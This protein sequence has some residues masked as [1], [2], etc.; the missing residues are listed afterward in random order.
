[1]TASTIPTTMSV[2]HFVG[3]GHIGVI[4]KPVGAPGSGQLLLQVKANALCGSERGQFANGSTVTPGH[5]AAGIVVAAGPGTHTPIG[6]PGV[7][8]LI[9][10]CGDCRSC[11]LGFTNQCLNKR[12]DMGFNKDGGYG[13]FETVSEHI[14]FPVDDDIPLADA[15]MLLD[16]MGTSAHAIKRGLQIRAD[17]ESVLITG[18]G[19]VGLGMLAMT[20]LLLGMATPVLI[21]DI[22]PYRLAL[23]ERLGGVPID[24]RNQNL[25]DGARAAGFET[26]DMAIDT[27]GK[28]VAR[29]AALDLLGKRGALVCVGHGEEVHLTVSS[30]LIAPERAVLGSEYFCFNELPASLALLRTHR[31]YLGQIITHRYPVSDIQHAFE[32]FFAG[33]TGKVVIE[34]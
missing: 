21:S 13:A 20:K 23:A 25:S 10:Y 29:Q 33:S 34:Q 14:F 2:P 16:V 7:V 4:Q 28:T 3:K 30:M 17:V 26:V 8:F 18:S 12:G 11:R 9:D 27:S 31:Q 24:L 6:T 19:P 22:V 1:M 15:T 5:E 32:L